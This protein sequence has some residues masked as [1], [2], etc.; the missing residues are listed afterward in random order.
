MNCFPGIRLPEISWSIA[1]MSR[2]P[3]LIQIE[4]YLP[5]ARPCVG[6][7]RDTIVTLKLFDRLW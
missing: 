3:Q 6:Q 5:D 2:N 7:P 4:H 1:K